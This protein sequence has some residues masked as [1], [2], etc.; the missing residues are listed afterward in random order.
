VSARRAGAAGGR[1][2][3]LPDEARALLALP[4]ARFTAARDDLARRLA[5]EDPAAAAAVR[6]LRRPVG[7]AWL[8]NRA[9]RDAPGDV[10]A[11]LAAADGLR[12][13]GGGARGLR[14]AEDSLRSAARALRLVAARAAAAEGAR[15]ID[16]PRLELLVR[17]AA[18]ADPATREALRQGALVREPEAALGFEAVTAG[19][20]ARPSTRD[21]PA[22]AKPA[23]PKAAAQAARRREREEAAQARRRERALERARRALRAAEA[24]AGAA[25]R[26]AERLEATARSAQERAARADAQV[27]RVRAALEALERT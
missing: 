20:A 16:L 11:L 22:T 4:P 19:G 6:A 24:E 26:E 3:P 17:V 1:D 9:A 14:D 7:L 15:S 2:G 5:R 8:L 18:G 23:P 25:R 21:A 10:E 12:A 13:G 27:A